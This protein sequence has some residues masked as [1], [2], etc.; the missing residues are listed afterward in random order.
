MNEAPLSETKNAYKY[1][2][3]NS[4]HIPRMTLYAT[5]SLG[6]LPQAH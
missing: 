1:V 6:R 2:Y 4:S 5:L 3:D